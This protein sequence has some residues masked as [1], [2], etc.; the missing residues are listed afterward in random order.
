MSEPYR[1]MSW[2]GSMR[3]YGWSFSSA[4]RCAAAS[5]PGKTGA[6]P[7]HSCCQL[8]SGGQRSRRNALTAVYSKA[9]SRSFLPYFM[10]IECHHAGLQG[11]RA[12]PRDAS[13]AGHSH[14]HGTQ[15]CQIVRPQSSPRGPAAVLP[16]GSR[17]PIDFDRR[18][19]AVAKHGA[20]VMP[21]QCRQ[22]AGHA[23]DPHHLVSEAQGDALG[24]FKH[25]E[26]PQFTKH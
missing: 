15:V 21:V 24:D 16:K 3:A 19:G 14:L 22:S 6:W 26:E 2:T 20:H 9:R 10:Q 25:S 23:V 4:A 17:S 18:P 7:S 13:Q 11:N 1:Q 12:H 5:S 8:E